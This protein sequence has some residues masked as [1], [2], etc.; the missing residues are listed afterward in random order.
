MYL[1]DKLASGLGWKGADDQ[2]KQLYA[3]H[4]WW[5]LME[6]H[7]KMAADT[8]RKYRPHYTSLRSPTGSSPEHKRRLS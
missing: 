7:Q 5:G 6:Q 4:R 1:P 2:H 8:H 3:S